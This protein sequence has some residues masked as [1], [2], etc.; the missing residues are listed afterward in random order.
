MSYELASTIE[1]WKSV[2]KLDGSRR[3]SVLETLGKVQQGQGSVHVHKL[4]GVPFVSFG[5]TKDAMRVVCVREGKLLLMCHVAS[6]DAAYDWARRHKLVQVGRFVRILRSRVEQAGD[7]PPLEPANDTTAASD[8]AA[9]SAPEAYHASPPTTEPLTGPLAHVPDAVFGTFDIGPGASAALRQV[10]DEDSL[11]SLLEHFPTAR[12]EALLALA[13]DPDDLP[14]IENA[15]LR[16]LEA[17]ERGEAP[18]PVSFA[19]AL[20]DEVNAGEILSPDAHDNA[21]R[22]A[23]EGDFAAWRVFLHPSQ[24]RVVR[25]DAKKG[26]VKVTG[27]PGTGKTVVALHRAR[28]LATKLEGPVLLTTFNA[29]LAQQLQEGVTQLCGHEPEVLERITVASLTRVAQSILR[30]AGRPDALITDVTG[31]WKEALA[32]DTDDRGRRFYESEREH[33]VA[34]ADAWTKEAYLRV[35]RTGRSEGLDR[36]ARQRVWKVLETFE[37]GLSARKGGDSI[38]L[39]REATRALLEGAA[40]S[41]YLA[42]ICDEV[43]DVGASELRLLAALARDPSTDQLRPNGLTLC[44]DGHQRIYRVPVSLKSCGI[45]VRGR[46]SRRLRLNY[47]TTDAIRRYAVAV[48][49]GLPLDDLD[50][51]SGSP[52][53]GYRSLRAGVPPEH[54]SFATTAEEAGWIADRARDGGATPLLVLARRR[55]YLQELRERLAER[56]LS[57][58][59]LGPKDHLTGQEALVLCTMHRAKGLEAPRVIIAGKQLVPARF[60]GGDEADRALWDR[61]ERALLYVALTRARDWCATTRVEKPA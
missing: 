44:G 45:D 50:A 38:A 1:F 47:R 37:A 2:E 33:V 41:P 34:R 11:L 19:E 56:G 31:C 20:Q 58:T 10:P 26:A 25:I 22:Q 18:P 8:G 29:T 49:E 5:V 57:A 9:A 52:L 59:I 35:R 17:Q 39:A 21:Y 12:A 40:K 14:T 28:H 32:H 27:G 36:R 43:Q 54:H 51:D 23:L 48:V 46:A 60:P 42:V 13:T 7:G 16:A 61:K 30:D 53:E 15:Y 55:S 4:Q 3:K 6:H 24:R